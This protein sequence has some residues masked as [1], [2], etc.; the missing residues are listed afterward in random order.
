MGKRGVSLRGTV[1]FQ[2]LMF[3]EEFFYFWRVVIFWYSKNFFASSMSVTIYIT[4]M[5]QDSS[6][7]NEFFPYKNK[8]TCA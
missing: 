7:K 6:V 2:S 1:A 3:L 4:S 8:S 5:K